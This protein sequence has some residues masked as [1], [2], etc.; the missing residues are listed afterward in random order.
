MGVRLSHNAYGKHSV[1]VSKIRRDP[2]NPGHHE[3]IEASVNVT[4]QG[5]LED[6]YIHGDNR[7]V[8]ATDTCKN[9][10]YVVAKDDSFVSI[11]SFGL[12][13]AKHFL[14]QYSHFAQV[15]I[16]IRQHTWHRLGDCGHGFIGSDSETPT[17]RIELTRGQDPVLAAGID[18][19]MIAKTT[20][21]GFKD[22]HRDEFRTLADT[23]DRILASV[24]TSDWIYTHCEI[25]HAGVR[26]KVRLAL[27]N[28]FLD[29]YSR[30]V[31]ET[32]M[33]MGKAVLEACEEISSIRLTMPN[34]HHI[35]VNLEPFGRV[36]Q[37]DVFVVT[38]EPFGY[39]TAKVTRA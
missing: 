25:D 32:M 19:L 14:G 16:E 35:P 27:L 33:L 23:D 5:D 21:T 15:T 4:I 37:N 11:E 13:L 8:V 29:H 3:F 17:A 7:N 18:G 2:A 1:R 28:K 6:A 12:A 34:K 10:V 30:S 39:I 36:N 24:V 26:A 22:F 31:Q 9:T 38:D 20:A